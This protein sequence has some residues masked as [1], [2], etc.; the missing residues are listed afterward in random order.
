MRFAQHADA[1]ESPG[2]ASL[3][4]GYE[5][6]RATNAPRFSVTRPMPPPI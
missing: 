4:P 6:T 3:S 2:I 1:V 5:L